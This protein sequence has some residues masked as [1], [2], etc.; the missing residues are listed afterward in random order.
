MYDFVRE[1]YMILYMDHH[2]RILINCIYFSFIIQINEHVYITNTIMGLRIH[3]IHIINLWCWISTWPRLRRFSS[4]PGFAIATACSKCKSI[5]S[6]W[7]GTSLH[8]P[9]HS[10]VIVTVIGFPEQYGV[11]L[12]LIWE[13]STVNNDH[14]NNV[15]THFLIY[16]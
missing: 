4:C 3:K 9:G 12:H 1:S 15:Y 11:R 6:K 10:S 14:N 7:N 2:S 13:K 5:K 8:A 16:L